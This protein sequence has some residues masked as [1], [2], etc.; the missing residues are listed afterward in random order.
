LSAYGRTAR[1]LA[2]AVDNPIRFPGQYYDGESGLHY[3]RF[4]YYDPMVGRYINQDPIGIKGGM[5]FYIYVK[6]PIN[7]T[8]YLGLQATGPVLLGMG[9]LYRS[10]IF[11]TMPRVIQNSSMSGVL[12]EVSNFPWP[13]PQLPGEWSGVNAPWTLPETYCASGYYGDDPLSDFQPTD[14]SGWSC[15]SRMKTNG[16]SFSVRGWDERKFTCSK[17]KLVVR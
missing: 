14:N 13:A 8:D 16:Q 9:H 7:W 2:H 11:P 1:R 3:N 6:N 4:R 5:N 12:G 15:K 10:D 17:I